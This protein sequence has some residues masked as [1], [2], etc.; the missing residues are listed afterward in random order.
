M[1]AFQIHRDGNRSV[2]GDLVAT[3]TPKGGEAQEVGK[4]TGV[5]VYVPN[6]LR[7][8]QLPL[9]LPAEGEQRVGTYGLIFRER[10]EAGGKTMAEAMLPS[11]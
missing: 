3:F 11:P 7:R 1:L 5:A 6:A 2:Y 10:P 4:A 8:V 9:R